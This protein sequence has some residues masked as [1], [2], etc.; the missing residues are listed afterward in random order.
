REILIDILEEKKYRVAKASN[1]VQA[2][3]RVKNKNYDVIFIDF[4]MPIING[5]ELYQILRKFKPDIKAI[6][7]TG[8]G[9]EI[10][11]LA[12]E[13]VKKNAYACI[14]K[15]FE[16]EKILE[17]IEQILSGMRKNAIQWN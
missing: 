1:A 10:H 12:E 4:I 17:L 6:M 11:D 14:Y 9:L 5:L 3:T 15:P 7:M 2:I 8:Y 16:V 13:A